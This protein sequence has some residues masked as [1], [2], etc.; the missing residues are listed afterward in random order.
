[1]VNKALIDETAFRNSSLQAAYFNLAATR[2]FL[3]TRDS[4][5]RPRVGCDRFGDGLAIDELP[6][7]SADDQ[8]SFAQNFEMVGD[9]CGGHAAHRHDLAAAHVVLCRDG[10]ENS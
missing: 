8:P 5:E 9:G 4:R 10:R 2:C 3:A 1:M 6:F 7:T